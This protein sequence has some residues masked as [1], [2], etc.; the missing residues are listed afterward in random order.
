MNLKILELTEKEKQS[1][2]LFC[3]LEIT[4]FTNSQ[5]N[6]FIRISETVQSDSLTNF[7]YQRS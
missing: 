3:C 2:Y 6:L 4:Q 1:G 5:V 7:N